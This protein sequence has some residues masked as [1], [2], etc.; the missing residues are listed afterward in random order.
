M[1]VFIVDVFSMKANPL[2]LS[3]SDRLFSDSSIVIPGGTQTFSKMPYQHVAGVSPKLLSRGSGCRSW[4]VDGNEY[5]DYMMSLGPN[6][7]GYADEEINSAA[8]EGAKLGILSSLGHPLE[9]ELAKKLISIIPCAEMVRF[10][11]N[12]S[13]VTSAS[14][15][16]ARSFTGRDKILVCGYHGWHDWYIGSTSRNLGVPKEVQDLTLEFQYNNIASLEAA[17]KSNPKEIAAVIMEPVN[18]IEPDDGFLEKVK[19]ITHDNNALLIFDEVITGFRMDIGGAQSYYNVIPDLACFGKAMANG[20]PMSALVGK[21]DIM[22]IFEE[23]FFSGTFAADLVSIS[24]SIATI[25]ALE[26]RGT[27]EHI[28]SMGLRLKDGFNEI[29]RSLELTHLTEMI[30]YGW[31]PEYLFY[32]E[33]GNVSLEIQS[34]FQQEIVRRGILTRAGIFLCG[35]HQI[36]HIDKTLEAFQEALIIV[37]EAVKED[38]VLSWLDGEVLKP[39][40]RA[41]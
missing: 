7:L 32:D 29:A 38:K 1:E 16:A 10:G 37:S 27:L 3:E 34:L 39:V 25:K 31:W 18:F 36:S 24:A 23:S 8:F 19:S 2:N 12:G 17:F 4:D 33:Q 6:I 13:D 41:K 30:G 22:A 5:I 14:I 15:R 11:K 20:Y 9:A 40:I 26:E 21:A 35:S 28:N